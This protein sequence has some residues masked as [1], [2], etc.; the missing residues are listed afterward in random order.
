MDEASQSILESLIATQTV[1]T[2]VIN[3]LTMTLVQVAVESSTDTQS[4]LIARK[5]VS[6]IHQRSPTALRKAVDVLSEANLGLE[7][8]LEQLY[9]SLSTVS[10]LCRHIGTDSCLEK[11]T[12]SNGVGHRKESDLILSASNADAKV[13]A[14]AVKQ[15]VQSIDGKEFSAIEDFV[16]VRSHN[17]AIVLT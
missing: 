5:M 10:S 15:L 1:P 16:C 14:A 13:R 3:T 2:T 8:A 17:S 6:L 11:V 12:I 4:V 7:E 9:I